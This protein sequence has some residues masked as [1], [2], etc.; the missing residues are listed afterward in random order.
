MDTRRLLAGSMALGLAFA[1]API[2]TA[3]CNGILGI[4]S[5][6]VASADGGG[7]GGGGAGGGGGKGDTGGEGG[8]VG[9]PPEMIFIEAGTFF[10]EAE[11]GGTTSASISSPFW[12]D[13]FEVT[14]ARFQAWLDAGRPPPCEE[15]TCP[16][17]A[18]GPYTDVMTWLPQWGSHLA[19][20]AYG[21][22]KQCSNAGDANDAAP[23]LGEGDGSF[24]IVCVNWYQAVAF[25]AWEGKR[26][27]TETEWQYVA[28]GRGEARDYPWGFTAPVGCDRAIW[29]DAATAPSFNGCGFPKPVGSASK[30]ASRDGVY[31]M[32]GSVFE[33]LW[34]AYALYPM[35]ATTSYAGPPASVDSEKKLTRGGSFTWEEP[36]L[37]TNDRNSTDSAG[38]H[39]DIGIRCAKSQ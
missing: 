22:P 38:I 6:K 12:V 21:D 19:S 34:D 32:G 1:L 26:L 31:D 39:A 27:L 2:S 33:W 10:F 37:R 7:A 29:R 15:T 36:S 14:V 13:T 28:S 20:T 17:D 35:T 30:G 25:C 5:G 8:G 11:E 4:R 18:N 3:G 23:T 9:S 24:P 16:L